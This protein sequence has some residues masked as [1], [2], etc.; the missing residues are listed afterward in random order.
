M[1]KSGTLA[2]VSTPPLVE[3]PDW[4][5]RAQILAQVGVVTVSDLVVTE[6]KEL[7]KLLK[8]PT[9]TIKDWK[10]EVLEWLNPEPQP[11]N[12]N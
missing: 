6:E 2:E 10:R 11:S 8:R 1:I 4:D 12:S 3:L 7:S 9:K 5:E